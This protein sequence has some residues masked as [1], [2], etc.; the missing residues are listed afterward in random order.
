VIEGLE[1][2]EDLLELH[3]ENQRLPAGEKLLFEPRTLL[4]LS[5]I[6]I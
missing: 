2:L 3:I 5:V 4:A 6:I 1:Q